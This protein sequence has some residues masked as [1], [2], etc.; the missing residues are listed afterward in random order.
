MFPV[1]LV[2]TASGYISEWA[3]SISLCDDRALYFFLIKI[4]YTIIL[5]KSLLKQ[6]F[7]YALLH[8][9]MHYSIPLCSFVSIPFRFHLVA[10]L[11]TFTAKYFKKPHSRSNC[12][13]NP[14]ISSMFRIS[15]RLL[16]K[17]G[18]KGSVILQKI[19]VLRRDCHYQN[20]FILSTPKLLGNK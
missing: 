17:L 20:T 15:L 14:L 19:K 10:A 3:K 5:K 2:F 11:K 1:F 13:P 8:I 7:P 18:S 9:E 6:T 4:T 12:N 16:I